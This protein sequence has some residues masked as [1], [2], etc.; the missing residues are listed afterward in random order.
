MDRLKLKLNGTWLDVPDGLEV[1]YRWV[2]NIF[3]EE[4][5]QRDRT[6]AFDLPFSPTNNK[7]LGWLAE[8]GT[9]NGTNTDHVVQAYIGQRFLFHASLRVNETDSNYKIYLLGKYGSLSDLIGEDKLTD[10]DWTVTWPSLDETDVSN[11]S[12]PSYPGWNPAVYFPLGHEKTDLISFLGL[13]NYLYS[14]FA[15]V[16]RDSPR[17]AP[18]VAAIIDAIAAHYGLPNVNMGAFASDAE[19]KNMILLSVGRCT[20]TSAAPPEGFLPDMKVSDFLR[21][22]EIMF[23]CQ[24]S[25][26]NQTQTLDVDFLRTAA[27][28]SAIIDWTPKLASRIKRVWENNVQAIKLDW[29]DS[30]RSD[31]ERPQ[32]QFS[33]FQNAITVDAYPPGTWATLS[34][35]HKPYFGNNTVIRKDEDG[36]WRPVTYYGHISSLAEKDPDGTRYVGAFDSYADLPDI[37]ADPFLY[38]EKIVY[39]TGERRYYYGRGTSAKWV[40]YFTECL[41][42]EEAGKQ[43]VF[44]PKLAPAFMEVE[45]EKINEL[46]TTNRFVNDWWRL[47]IVNNALI[48]SK[49]PFPQLAFKRGVRQSWSVDGPHLNITGY[50]HSY[51]YASSDEFDTDRSDAFNYSLHWDGEKG[52]Y[53][54]WWKDWA[55]LLVGGQEI[56]ASFNLNSVDLANLDFSRPI[57]VLGAKCYIKEIDLRMPIKGAISIKLLKVT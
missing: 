17:H 39:V 43:S 24:F 1:K 10:I 18:Y 22:L 44:T 15:S 55:R 5:K 14:P 42:F 27:N 45:F 48:P 6:L 33:D 12:Y 49:F 51:T 35:A 11:G 13:H 26:N 23:C 54:T 36:V 21:S 34:G 46:G 37:F 30:F 57:L 32:V 3:H 52:L 9:P 8:I 19:L 20:E 31:Y 28:N 2:N 47:P 41:P 38:D 16:A 25:I 29:D 50:N 40:Y 53:N 4:T 7:A 56:E